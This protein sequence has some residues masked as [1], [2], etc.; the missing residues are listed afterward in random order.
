MWHS[1]CSSLPCCMARDD[2]ECSGAAAEKAGVLSEG[3]SQGNVGKWSWEMRHNYEG[4][5][6][7]CYGWG[8]PVQ[9]GGRMG[10]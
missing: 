6:C 1:C 8:S 5:D 2:C 9:V 10:E 7:P 4:N 3:R